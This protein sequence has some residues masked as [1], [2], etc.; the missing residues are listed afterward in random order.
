MFIC[1]RCK[2][3]FPDLEGY[4]MRVQYQ[5]GYGSIHDGDMFDLTVCNECVDSIANAVSNV[6][7]ISPIASIDYGALYGEDYDDSGDDDGGDATIFS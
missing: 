3:I 4:G 7:A 1:N 5:F 2:K 6:C